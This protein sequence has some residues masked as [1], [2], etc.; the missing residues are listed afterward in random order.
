MPL[1]PDAESMPPSP[2]AE[3]TPLDP[4]V[5]S[6]PLNSDAE[7]TPL[8]PDA[9][10]IVNF[11]MGNCRG[12]EMLLALLMRDL[13]LPSPVSYAPLICCPLPLRYKPTCPSFAP[14]LSS[15][16]PIQAHHSL[17]RAPIVPSSCPRHFIRGSLALDDHC[18]HLLLTCGRGNRLNYQNIGNTILFNNPTICFFDRPKDRYRNLWHILIIDD[19]TRRSA[20]NDHQEPGTLL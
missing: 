5:E 16:S 8:N 13:S 19:V 2:D 20:S 9:E 3:S 18:S 6:I 14:L 10:T 17:S 11:Q 4:D 7:S 1:N 15:A 12:C